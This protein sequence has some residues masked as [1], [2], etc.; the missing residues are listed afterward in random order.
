MARGSRKNPPPS[1]CSP[2]VTRS[3]SNNN[4]PLQ[5]TTTSTNDPRIIVEPTTPNPTGG[6][7]QEIFYQ[8]LIRTH[9]DLAHLRQPNRPLGQ[10]LDFSNIREK[11]GG[12]NLTVNPTDSIL[13]PAVGGSRIPP[14][15]PPSSPS[16]S[17]RYSSDEGSSLSQPSTPTTP[18]ANHNN[19]LTGKN[20]R[21]STGRV[22]SVRGCLNNPS[23]LVWTTLTS[24]TAPLAALRFRKETKEKVDLS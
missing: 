7:I 11:L 22:E 17:T 12:T 14:S 20:D 16:S 24:L 13:N 5:T 19:L 15:P 9:S 18:M 23:R 3:H 21:P 4:I 1:N 2:R 10:P 8:S 6:D